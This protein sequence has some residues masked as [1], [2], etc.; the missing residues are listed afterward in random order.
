MN[1]MGRILTSYLLPLVVGAAFSCKSNSTGA[2]EEA[3]IFGVARDSSGNPVHDAN[4]NFIFRFRSIITNQVYAD[5][6][7]GAGGITLIMFAIPTRAFIILSIDNFV[8]DPITTLVSDTLNPGSY[9][10]Q[11]NGKDNQQRDV[12]S[13]C[14]F[15]KL[16]VNDSLHQRNKMVFITAQHLSMNAARYVQTDNYGRFTIP[17]SRLPVDEI[18][19]RTTIDP[20]PIDSIR[21]DDVQS[22][23]AFKGNTFG[24]ATISLS[25][26]RETIIILN[27]TRTD[28][29]IAP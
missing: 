6:P 28:T 10:I 20:T 17:L 27:V 16:R 19:V 22:L 15:W 25:D 11:W 29:I 7:A 2:G 23:Y 26:R 5:T 13:D 18:F 4:L 21:L 12:Y 14:F 3:V 1:G 24:H 8:G 9:Q